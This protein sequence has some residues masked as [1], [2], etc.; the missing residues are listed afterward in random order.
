LLRNE[1]GGNR[2]VRLALRGSGSNRDAIG[3]HV[4]AYVAS[5]T[6]RV[7][8]VKTGSSYLSQSE[9]PLTIGLGGLESIPKIEIAWPSGKIEQ[10][11]AV[12]AGQTVIVEEGRGIVGRVPFA[13]RPPAATSQPRP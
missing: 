1:G 7:Q 2:A 11:T 13:A 5:N 9:L 8:M 3:A 4:T 10:L 12:E 6:R